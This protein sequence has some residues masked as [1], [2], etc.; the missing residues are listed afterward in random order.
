[1]DGQTYHALEEPTSLNTLGLL[2]E[3]FQ[4]GIQSVK[5]EGRQRSPAYVEQVTRV[6][7][8]AIDAYQANPEAYQVKAEWDAQLAR[9]SEGARPPS[10]PI[11]A[12]GNKEPCS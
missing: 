7:R 3:L 2:P 8:A 10:V 4:T 11:I 5:I 12:S 6:W 9:V 1:V